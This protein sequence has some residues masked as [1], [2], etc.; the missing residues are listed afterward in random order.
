MISPATN[1]VAIRLQR[2]Y[3]MGKLNARKENLLM[4]FK[5][6]LSHLHHGHLPARLTAC[7]HIIP[8]AVKNAVRI[9]SMF[10]G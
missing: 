1:V 8:Y 6:S 7:D 10:L 3:G 4:A 5:T 2:V 9:D